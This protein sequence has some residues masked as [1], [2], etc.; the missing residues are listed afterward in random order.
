MIK[1][2]VF[3]LKN[4]IYKEERIIRVKSTKDLEETKEDLIKAL[5]IQPYYYDSIDGYLVEK[6]LS[7]LEQVN[8]VGV[9][10]EE[11]KPYIGE[12]G[13]E[14]NPYYGDGRMCRCG[15]SYDRHFDLS[16]YTDDYCSCGC[17]HCSCN[18]FIEQK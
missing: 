9:T 7:R 2:Y 16:E 14:Y 4:S 8:L 6:F 17:I 15:H 3:V 18:E 12:D 1:E 11:E 5:R 10:I 13:D